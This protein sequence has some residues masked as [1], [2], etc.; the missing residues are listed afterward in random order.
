MKGW[1]EFMVARWKSFRLPT[2]IAL[3]LAGHMPQM[4]LSRLRTKLLRAGGISIGQ[5]SMVMGD[6][7][8]YGKGAELA[9]L[10]SVG[11]N[12]FITGPLYV[13]VG[14]EVRVGD[15]VNIGHDVLL[16]TFHPETYDAPVGLGGACGPIHIGD[17]AWIASRVVVLPGVSVGEG[18]VVAAGA[19]VEKD[20]EPHTLVGGVPARL[21]RR[22]T[23]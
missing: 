7:R 10:F 23:S 3:R 19:V 1:Q 16:L 11:A 12:T 13:S 15:S 18:A 22:L 6:I 20:V 9:S 4:T 8:A 14:A 5:G 2:A 17:G 21:L